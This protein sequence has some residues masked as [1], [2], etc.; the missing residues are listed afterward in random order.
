MSFG[1]IGLAPGLPIQLQRGER[2]V[3]LFDGDF[4]VPSISIV[5][6]SGACTPKRIFIKGRFAGTFSPIKGVDFSCPEGQN[7]P[8]STLGRLRTLD[9]A[10]QLE[11]QL[12]TGINRSGLRC[13]LRGI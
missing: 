2:V 8:P 9:D 6:E 11:K 7:P 4:A 3:D 13:S 10:F 12:W 1:E 5:P